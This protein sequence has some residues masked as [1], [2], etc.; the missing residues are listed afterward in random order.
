MRRIAFAFAMILLA[1]GPMVA[2]AQTDGIV[3]E[4]PFARATPP[5]AKNGAVYMTIINHGAAADRLVAAASPAAGRAELHETISDNGV[6]KMR[7]VDGIPVDRDGKAVLKPGGL[8]LMLLDLKAP[9]KQGRTV[10]VTLVFAK[11]GKITITVP[12]E[13]PGAMGPGSAGMSGM[14]M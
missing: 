13:K 9:L 3:V 10:T 7:P 14:S 2:L 8:H 12:I 1:S 5:G 6:M 11:A 4:Q